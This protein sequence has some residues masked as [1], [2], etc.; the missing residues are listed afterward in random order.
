MLCPLLR[1]TTGTTA[2]AEEPGENDLEELV[3]CLVI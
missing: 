3:F 1:P 2:S